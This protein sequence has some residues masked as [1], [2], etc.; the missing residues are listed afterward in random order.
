MRK[1]LLFITAALFPAFLQ[2]QENYEIQVYA[3]P[4]MAKG[5]TIFELHSN[6]TVKGDKTGEGKLLPSNHA[7]HETIEITHGWNE[8]FE[9][10]IYFFNSIGSNGRTSYVG[11]HIRPRVAIPASWNWPVGLSLSTEFGFQKSAFADNTSGIEIRPII[12]K[13]FSNLY[14]AF[15]PTIERGFS[16]PD[17]DKK[18]SFAPNVKAA[19]SIWPKAA[20]GVEYYGSTGHIFDTAPVA[21]QQHQLFLATDLYFDPRW[22]FNAGLGYGLTDV[23]DRMIA[24]IILGRRF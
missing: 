21:Q 10:G 7:I 14:L 18:F 11:S 17:V 20:F 8:W 23:T 9:T 6:Y 24:K 3:S 5:K 13:T 2:A 16:G 12:D 15:N 19:Y 22:E 1:H 4:T